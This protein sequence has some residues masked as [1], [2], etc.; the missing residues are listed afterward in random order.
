MG[1]PAPAGFV[2]A[3]R[4]AL[5]RHVDRP[6]ERSLH[7]AYELGRRALAD[8]MS[9]LALSGIH[10][11]L[12]DHVLPSPSELLARA[13]SFLREGLAS[14]EIAALAVREGHTMG[15]AE[16][17]RTD[18]LGHLSDAPLAILAAP[19]VQARLQIVCER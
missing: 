13:D 11:S 17:E 12:R 14:F 19:S 6:S 1:D 10:H 7:D 2:G 15:A 4:D 5:R 9:L 16:R 8:G 3:Y 18:V